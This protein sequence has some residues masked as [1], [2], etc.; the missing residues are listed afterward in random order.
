MY[1]LN[2][3]RCQA[4]SPTEAIK[5]GEVL[6][7]QS[8]HFSVKDTPIAVPITVREMLEQYQDFKRS[9]KDDSLDYSAYTA[10]ISKKR[11]RPTAAQ[12]DGIKDTQMN[13]HVPTRTLRAKLVSPARRVN[14]AVSSESE[15]EDDDDYDD[16]QYWPGRGQKHRRISNGGRGKGKK[17]SL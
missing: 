9:L 4:F 8:I 6:S 10:N 3:A 5:S 14:K 7:R 15:N 17:Q 11:A 2:D 12:V 13:G 1:S 16:D